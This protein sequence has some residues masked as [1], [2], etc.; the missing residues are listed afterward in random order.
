MCHWSRFHPFSGCKI[1]SH[2]EKEWNR[3]QWHTVSQYYLNSVDSSYRVINAEITEMDKQM[4]KLSA[5]GPLSL[6][7]W[8]KP[9]VAYANVLTRGVYSARTERVEANT[10]HYLPLLPT[11][12]QHNRMARLGL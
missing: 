5:G 6:V 7:A 3:D 1:I 11:D 10:P 12:E 8:E 9:T 2:P 4:V